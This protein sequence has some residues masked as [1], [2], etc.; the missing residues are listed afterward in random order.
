MISEKSKQTKNHSTISLNKIRVTSQLNCF[1]VPEIRVHERLFLGFLYRV[2]LYLVH[3][4]NFQIFLTWNMTT[5]SKTFAS[6]TARAVFVRSFLTFLPQKTS[7]L[8]K[9]NFLTMENYLELHRS[10]GDEICHKNVT[11]ELLKKNSWIE[12]LIESFLKNF[13]RTFLD[14]FSN[15]LQAPLLSQS[16]KKDRWRTDK[17]K[18]DS[19]SICQDTPK[20]VWTSNREKHFLP[21]FDGHKQSEE[22]LFSYG[23]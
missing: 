19:F 2:Y 12:I 14:F 13:V 23:N 10:Q 21:L 8:A 22:S 9:M 1:D 5:I 7:F 16:W 18:L 15:I 4:L 11:Q 3:K 6:L 17:I 20:Q